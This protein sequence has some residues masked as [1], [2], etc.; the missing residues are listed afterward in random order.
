MQN[1]ICP[2]SNERVPEHLPRITAFINIALIAF[3]IST[4]WLYLLVFLCIDFLLRGFNFSSL[5]IIHWLAKGIS[6]LFQFKTPMID[7]APKL[8]AA[9]LGGLM[10][11]LSVVFFLSGQLTATFI[12]VS[13]VAVLSTLECVFSFCAGCYI[14]Q[15]VVLP[16][17][18]RS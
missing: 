4:Q 3:Y 6:A 9:R 7:K 12:I 14:Y 18:S 2:I 17:Y 16:F 5:S 1:V 8:F 13:L 10:F 15:Y 11:A